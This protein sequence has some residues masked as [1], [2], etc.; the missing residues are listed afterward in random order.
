MLFD[1]TGGSFLISPHYINM[2]RTKRTAIRINPPRTIE[3]TM[4]EEPYGFEP[5]VPCQYAGC[6]NLVLT[7]FRV[8]GQCDEQ[9]SVAPVLI[10]PSLLQT[11]ISS[12][13]ARSVATP[14]IVA[15]DSS[16][17]LAHSVPL[18]ITTGWIK[19]LTASCEVFTER[20]GLCSE[21]EAE[22]VRVLGVREQRQS[23]ER[24][25]S[26]YNRMSSSHS[27]PTAIRY[28]SY[29]PMPSYSQRKKLT[30]AQLIR[31]KIRC[32]PTLRLD[33]KHDS[34]RV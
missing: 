23:S 28:N 24:M 21:C 29:M 32:K 25:R 1:R 31:T 9:G 10:V 26:D 11:I 22:R 34:I 6:H 3:I 20:R 19:C 7:G 30:R 18:L 4:N 17:R 5:S 33:K 2:A 13:P 14:S 16:S 8:C 27:R 12:W 15:P